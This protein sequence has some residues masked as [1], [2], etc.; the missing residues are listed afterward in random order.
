MIF[1]LFFFFFFYFSYLCIYDVL[2]NS[3]T[4]SS[5]E[6]KIKIRKLLCIRRQ[7]A[8]IGTHCCYTLNNVIRKISIYLGSN[9]IIVF[10]F[11]FFLEVKC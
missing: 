1:P 11:F 4:S 9:F 10:F 5:R 6:K 3:A 2:Y 8:N 7:G